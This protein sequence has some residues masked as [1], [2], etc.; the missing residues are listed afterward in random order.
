MSTRFQRSTLQVAKPI[1]D[2]LE[3]Q[4]EDLREQ[5]R[6][7]SQQLVN[8]ERGRTIDAQALNQARRS[9]VDLETR[10]ASLKAD[11]TFYKNIMA[12]SETSKGLQV[13]RFTMQQGRQDDR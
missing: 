9:I 6:E 7:A 11:L 10:I 2:L 13:D 5:N 4:V 1:L 3:E 8:L 12:P